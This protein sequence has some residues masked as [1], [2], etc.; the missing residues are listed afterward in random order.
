[1][2]KA[3]W[4]CFYWLC[5]YGF[6]DEH[7]AVGHMQLG[8]HP[9]LRLILPLI[10]EF[11]SLMSKRNWPWCDLDYLGQQTVSRIQTLCGK[12]LSYHLLVPWTLSSGAA[13]KSTGIVLSQSQSPLV[14]WTLYQTLLTI[15]PLDDFE[16]LKLLPPLSNHCDY[17]PVL[18]CLS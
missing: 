4:V 8:A 9:C 12:Y 18:Q 3:C 15:L 2:N 10:G 11:H 13:R 14:P 6:R 5:V 7:F 16:I 17:R 1:M